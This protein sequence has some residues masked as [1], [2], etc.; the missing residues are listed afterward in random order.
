MKTFIQFCIFAS[1]TNE[2]LETFIEIKYVLN[3]SIQSGQG[4]GIAQSL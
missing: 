2:T 4:D 1:K 3:V